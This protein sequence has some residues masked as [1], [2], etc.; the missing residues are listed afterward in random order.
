MAQNRKNQTAAMM[1]GPAIKAALFCLMIVISCVGYVW[2]KRQIRDLSRMIAEKEQYLKTLREQNV[3]LRNQQVILL[4]PPFLD[5]R[6]K[7]LKLGLG[8]PAAAQVWRLPE[9]AAGPV[10]AAV[11]LQ[12]KPLAPAGTLASR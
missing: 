4:S 11:V 7:E 2:Q 9:P 6:A 5:Q 3:K 10:S 12:T 1:F 8:L